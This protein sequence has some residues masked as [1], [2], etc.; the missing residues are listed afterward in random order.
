MS[1]R[2]AVETEMLVRFSLQQGQEIRR[3]NYQEN[4]GTRELAE[5]L[6][7]NWTSHGFEMAFKEFQAVL[8]LKG[9]DTLRYHWGSIA[10]SKCSINVDCMKR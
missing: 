7:R 2:I 3:R 6:G 4:A 9:Q 5:I 8:N 1:G 10:Y